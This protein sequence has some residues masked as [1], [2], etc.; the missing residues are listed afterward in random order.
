MRG[1]SDLHGAMGAKLLGGK[2]WKQYMNLYRLH[3]MSYRT[4]DGSF[5]ATPTKESKSM[6]NNTDITVGPRWTTATYVI[7]LSLTGEN[8]PY[9]MGG[10]GKKSKSGK[11]RITLKPKRP[12]T[13]GS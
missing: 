12:Q 8:L 9:L 2:V 3:I 1:V 5:S 13:G 4:P 6:R 7:I 11:K 10:K